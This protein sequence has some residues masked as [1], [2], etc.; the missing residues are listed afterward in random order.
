MLESALQTLIKWSGSVGLHTTRGR[1]RRRHP[2]PF[3]VNPNAH[4]VP[5]LFL[6]IHSGALVLLFGATSPGCFYMMRLQIS[7][8]PASAQP[9]LRGEG[10]EV[11][12][13]Q[14]SSEHSSTWQGLLGEAVEESGNLLPYPLGWACCPPASEHSHCPLG[15]AE[16][17]PRWHQ[18]SMAPS[19]SPV[20]RQQKQTRRAEE[21][22]VGTQ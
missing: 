2:S 5:H 6:R 3:Q 17:R 1:A 8:S 21:G 9:A 11:L 4:E 22:L 20:S 7:P 16:P 12:E 19:S 18:P 10:P 14:G 13:T 15:L